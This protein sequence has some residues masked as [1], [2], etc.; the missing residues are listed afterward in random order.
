MVKLVFQSLN[1][2]S[3]KSNKLSFL[4]KKIFIVQHP[5]TLMISSLKEKNIIYLLADLQ[6]L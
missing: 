2:N 4:K 1:G 3:I 6:V 5:T